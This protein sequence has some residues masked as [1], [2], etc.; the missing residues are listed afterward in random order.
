MKPEQF[1]REF[2]ENKA[3]EVVELSQANIWS[4]MDLHYATAPKQ[5]VFRSF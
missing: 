1:I 4:V 5:K 3:R 2:G